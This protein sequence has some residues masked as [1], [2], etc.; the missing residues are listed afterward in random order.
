MR[1]GAELR[2]RFTAVLV[3]AA[4][5]GV[6][7]GVVIAAA[8]GARRTDT[9]YARFVEAKNGLDVV[10]DAQ[11]KDPE[12]ARRLLQRMERLPQ[13]EASS[14][15]FLAP[16]GL[17]VAGRTKPANVFPLVSPD[18]RFGTTINGVK[19]L[20]G[21]MY[22]RSAAN[23]MV[24]SFSVADDLGLH[25]GDT[26]HLVCCGLFGAPGLGHGFEP[27]PPLAVHVVGIGAMPGM[28]QPLAGGYLPGVLL[29]SAFYRVH[30]EWID[31]TD[32][33]AAIVLRRGIDD[34]RPYVDEIRRLREHIPPHTRIS[35]PF[36]QAQ[37]TVGVLQATR[38]QAISLWVLGALVALAGIAIFAQA[39]ARQTFLESIEYPTLRSVGMS[40]S[41]LMAV[42]M[43]RAALIGGVGAVV[44]AVVGFLFSPLTPTGSIARI[45]EPTPGFL[46]DGAVVAVGALGTALIVILLGAIPAWR[47][48]RVSG[49]SLGTAEAPG[50]RRPSAVAAVM[51]RMAFPPSANAGVRM[52]MEP[53]RGRTAV[54]VRTTMFGATLSILALAAA[55]VFGASLDRLVAT[56]RLA[57]Y[58]WDVLMFANGQEKTT[59][60]ESII[61]DSPEVSAY[62]IGSLD[63]LDIRRLHLVSLSMDPR[64]GSVVPSI[65]QGR[66]PRAED[67]IALGGDTMSRLGV[68][69]G[70]T[71]PV[72]GRRASEQMRIVGRVAVPP[73]FFS[74]ARPGQGAALSPSG[75]ER[76]LGVRLLHG[77]GGLFVRFVP[78]TNQ[79][80]FHDELE[81]RLGH[82]FWL[83]QQESPQV[84]NLGGIGNVPLI[85]AAIV[86]LMAAATLAHTLVS[87]IR[88]RRLDLAILKTIG[89]VRFQVSAT[90]AWQATALGLIALLIGVPLGVISGRWGWNV[91]ADRLGV[92]PEVAVPIAAILLAVPATLL[93]A[94]LLAVVP[95]R[96]ASRMKAASVLRSE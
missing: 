52:A 25:V 94:N 23:E 56:P 77:E 80:A 10:A 32:Q 44:A 75:A 3:L 86:G 43:I 19:I 39:L 79:A 51:A 87:S 20:E 53:G 27:P 45:A 5:V 2:S 67:E 17:Q 49:T 31:E 68:G 74:F 4:I 26:V 55:L 64:K 35:M 28:F 73:L 24:P 69:I 41:Q 78:G 61:A 59:Q 91:F 11:S 82:I 34:V 38:A 71:V 89:F 95:G 76:I 36:N 65:A 40:P 81:S 50:S 37:Q 57:G 47:A 60:M 21:R 85:L 90:V 6:I 46:L 48:A 8:A 16:A 33:N 92:V 12:E 9:A 62:S 72:T 84:H 54:P 96:I 18:G 30:H 15:V 14:R 58:S 63:G 93:A 83:P 29:S 22:D 1:A 42:G 66:L 7:G 13:V 88:R 70:D